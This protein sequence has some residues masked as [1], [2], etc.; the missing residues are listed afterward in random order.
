ML[1]NNPNCDLKNIPESPKN[2][3]FLLKMHGDSDQHQPDGLAVI[4]SVIGFMK[5]PVMEWCVHTV[6][7]S[8]GTL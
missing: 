4:Y 7:S 3:Q 5:I 1:V 2:S 6:K 8:F